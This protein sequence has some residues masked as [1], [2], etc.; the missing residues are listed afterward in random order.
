MSAIP[1]N[2]TAVILPD[3]SLSASV[4]GV[5]VVAGSL[6]SKAVAFDAVPVTLPNT[7]PISVPCKLAAGYPICLVVAFINTV[8]SVATTFPVNEPV[9]AFVVAL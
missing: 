9:N 8:E 5:A 2:L 3:A 7:L 6:E 4:L 1:V